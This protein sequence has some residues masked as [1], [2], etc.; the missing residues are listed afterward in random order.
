MPIARVTRRA[1]FCSAHRLRREDWSEE[2]NREVYGDCGNPNWHGHNYVLD[3]TVAGP[4]DP[5][6]GFV[7]DFRVLKQIMHERVV[8]DVDHPQEGMVRTLGSMLK[9]DDTPL[10]IREWMRDPGQNTDEILEQHGFG[11]SEIEE[12]RDKGAVA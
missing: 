6:T 10:E 11:S 3:V 1:H 8:I 12:L 4:V 2:R 7:M 5:E 9:L